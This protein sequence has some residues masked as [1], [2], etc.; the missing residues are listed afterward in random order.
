M[1]GTNN[2]KTTDLIWS[3]ILGTIAFL[4]AGVIAGI[5]VLRLDN[6][7][8]ATL[9]AGGIGGLLL[10]LFNWKH[11]LTVRMAGAG[12]AG[13]LLGFWGGFVLAEGLV[14]GFGMLFPSIAAG[15]E[16]GWLADLLANLLMGL[17]FGAVF[18]GI[19]YGRKAI[20]IFS[21]VCGAAT[22]PFGLLVRVLNS[23]HWI[24][25]WLV[26]LFAVIGIVDINI[27]VMVTQFGVGAGLGIGL[28][29]AAK[30]KSADVSLQKSVY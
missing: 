10:G 16:G 9:V 20:R 2:A 14:G 13:V 21:L 4:I 12:F 28:Y 19:V 23:D 6:Y 1:S 24:K 27:V 7:I 30:P 8:L 3:L 5:V 18:G 17:L 22:L 29:H 26:D 25:E 15:F 11:Q